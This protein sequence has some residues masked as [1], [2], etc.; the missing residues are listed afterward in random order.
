MI[1]GIFKLEEIINNKSNNLF[2]NLINN[3]IIGNTNNNFLNKI[4]SNNKIYT[5]IYDKSTLEISLHSLLSN[6]NVI[7]YKV[8]FIDICRT[9]LPN[10]SSDLNY[11]NF[12][13]K[14]YIKKYL[15]NIYL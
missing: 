14:N 7:D 12:I 4:K 3:K 8:F 6:P 1:N 9:S 11:K 13:I 15:I 5:S 10:I 2:R